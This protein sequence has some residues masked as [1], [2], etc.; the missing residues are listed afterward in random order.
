MI[1]NRKL[2]PGR[3]NGDVQTRSGG[4][5][6]VALT[7]KWRGTLAESQEADV[8]DGTRAGAMPVEPVKH[9]FC[10]CKEKKKKRCDSYFLC[11][12]HF[13]SAD[14]AATRPLLSAP[15]VVRQQRPRTGFFSR[16]FWR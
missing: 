14:V 11:C 2:F 1:K 6:T 13:A 9:V 5:E 3:G 15:V 8:A 4:K 7:R 10:L 16:G 12:A